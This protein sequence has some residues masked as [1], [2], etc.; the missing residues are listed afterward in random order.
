[1]PMAPSRMAMRCARMAG[2]CWA[3]V[4]AGLVSMCG[5]YEAAPPPEG[6]L[7][8]SRTIAAHENALP[9]R[10]LGLAAGP[11]GAL[12]RHGRGAPAV[13]RRAHGDRVALRR[14]PAW[15]GKHPLVR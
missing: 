14:P 15:R 10:S 1:V 6:G 8:A 11:T 4:Y 2:S 3:R 7:G 13:R 9:H 5:L 12:R